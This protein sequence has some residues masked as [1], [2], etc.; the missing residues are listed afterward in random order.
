MNFIASNMAKLQTPDILCRVQ[1]QV[2]H[3]LP[4]ESADPIDKFGEASIQYTCVN[5]NL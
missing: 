4:K 2:G 3:V 5:H 1:Q